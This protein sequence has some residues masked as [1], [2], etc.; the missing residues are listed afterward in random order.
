MMVLMDLGSAG[1]KRGKE[2]DSEH[3]WEA[4]VTGC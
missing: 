2:E 1:G 4:D 3:I